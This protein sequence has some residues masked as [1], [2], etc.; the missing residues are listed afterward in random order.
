MPAGRWGEALRALLA[1]TAAGLQS[2]G[3]MLTARQVADT[4]RREREA[5]ADRA[6]QALV[7]AGMDPTKARAF[8]T[9]PGAKDQLFPSEADER[10]T[11]TDFLVDEDPTPVKGFASSRGGY[12]DPS[13]Q[14]VRGRVRPYQAPSTATPPRV[15]NITVQRTRPDGTTELVRAPDVAGA[16]VP[17]DTPMGS[18]KIREKVATN[19][20]NV[21]ALRDA[22]AELDKHPEMVGMQRG[23][24]TLIPLLGGQ[25]GG[26]QDAINQRKDPTG[27]SGRASLAN[28]GSLI[29]HDRSGAAVTLSEFP[30]LQPFIPTA[31]DT[32]QAVRDK[33]KKLIEIIEGETG[34]LERG[35]SPARPAPMGGRRSPDDYL[36]GIP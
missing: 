30:R 29:I 34:E 17:D 24:L 11:P 14:R 4:T 21:T 20:T 15:P 12:F 9:V 16:V 1:G 28:V 26:F 5:S 25:L 13:M 36:K 32:P 3:Q 27:V 33:V 22:V 18:A 2:G 35:L 23:W 8:V 19:R 6:V 31:T 7:A 10:F